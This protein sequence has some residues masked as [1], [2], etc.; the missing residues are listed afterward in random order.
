MFD[1]HCHL[2]PCIDDGPAN[3]DVS[4]MMAE[5]ALEDGIH[6]VVATPHVNL[7]YGVEAAQ[8]DA[9]VDELR[10]ALARAE[11]PLSLLAGAEIALNRLPGLTDEQVRAL[12]LGESSCALVESPYSPVGSLLEES[13]F[14]LH[15][16]GFRTLLAHPE[17]CPE[18]QRDVARL[19]RLVEG[20]AS[21]SISAGS[22]AG[23]FGEPVREFALRLLERGLVHNV[24]SDAHDPARR[25]PRL[26]GAVRAGKGPLSSPGLRLWL[27]STVP[28]ALLSNQPLPPPP[29]VAGPSRWKRLTTRG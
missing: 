10:S 13:V 29:P 8:I 2:L 25:A 7:R 18:L 23:Q 1:L 24:S 16:R 17:R 12:C 19:E 20:G 3:I 9:K 27:T 21:C 4:L 6:T 28:M 5:T 15:A 22:I 11:L 26:R 14:D